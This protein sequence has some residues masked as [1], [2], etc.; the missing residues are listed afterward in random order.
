MASGISVSPALVRL[1]LAKDQ[2][3]FTLT[4]FNPSDQ[5]VTIHLSA[6]DFTALE[7]GWRINF[8]DT[9]D[10]Q[11]YHYSLSSWLNFSSQNFILL[12]Q[13]SQSILVNVRQS[14]L[15]TGAHYASVLADFSPPQSATGSG[16]A[17]KSELVSLVFVRTH[18]GTERDEAKINSFSPL[19]TRSFILPNNYLVRF[20]NSGN[21]DLVPHG[22]IIVR[23]FLNREVGRG[24]FNQ[25]QAIS[26][27]ETIRTYPPILISI[28]QPLYRLP[29]PYQAT[30]TIN[31]AN[32]TL[33]A[34]TEFFSFG[35][36]LNFIFIFFILTLLLLAFRQ[37]FL[38]I[39]R[40]LSRSE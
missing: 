32:Q 13:K 12:P 21:T 9:S 3:Q 20:D 39:K 34:Y 25:E 18:T 29:G 15:S 17:I 24:I 35:S 31:Y 5:A 26:L 37:L 40:L 7:Q 38:R 1:D 11:S 30:L 10:S 28:N 36:P 2:P 6:K 4:Y 8:L 33:T 19:F 23:D 16:I 27:P 14:D 22:V